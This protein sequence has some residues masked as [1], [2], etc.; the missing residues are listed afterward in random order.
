MEHCKTCWDGGAIWRPTPTQKYLDHAPN[1]YTFSHLTNTVS[2]LEALVTIEA[3]FTRKLIDGTEV[4]ARRLPVTYC[5]GLEGV[6]K[7]LKDAVFEPGTPPAV[8][9]K[10][11]AVGKKAEKFKELLAESFCTGC[12]GELHGMEA[13]FAYG[14]ETQ[15]CAGGN[16]LHVWSTTCYYAGLAAGAIRALKCTNCTTTWARYRAHRLSPIQ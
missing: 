8:T 10:F 6:E 15:F 3:V 9:N 12:F 1:A 5:I 2:T 7:A 11:R 14:S 4:D 16:A 13:V